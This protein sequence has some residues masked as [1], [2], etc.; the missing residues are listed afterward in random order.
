[1]VFRETAHD[2]KFWRIE[3]EEPMLLIK[4]QGSRGRRRTAELGR[5]KLT[6]I[7][8]EQQQQRRKWPRIRFVKLHQVDSE[9]HLTH[10]RRGKKLC[11]EFQR[12][13]GENALSWADVLQR[14]SSSA[15]VL[16]VLAVLARSR[17]LSDG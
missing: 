17:P 8:N 3:L 5:A 10:N 15:P 13:A 4:G 2:T 1:M 9:G 7:P 11:V 14:R 6:G 16:P 12:G